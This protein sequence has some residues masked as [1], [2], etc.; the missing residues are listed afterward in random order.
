MSTTTDKASAWDAMSD[1]Q[2]VEWLAT[3]V[4]GFNWNFSSGSFTKTHIRPSIALFSK[5][6]WNPLTSWDAWRQ[7]EEKVMEDKELPFIYI[8][9]LIDD[10]K[11]KKETYIYHGL[12]KADLHTRAKSLFLADQYL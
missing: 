2:K 5:A 6:D 9:K 8:G 12:I 10:M 1:E 4:M 7:V 11:M 3:R